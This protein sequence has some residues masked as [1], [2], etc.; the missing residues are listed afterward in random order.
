[1]IILILAIGAFFA[2]TYLL[3][4]G[5]TVQQKEIAVS[6]RKAKS[7]RPSRSA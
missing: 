6:M 5:L 3:L 2:A 7:L 1:M 4:T